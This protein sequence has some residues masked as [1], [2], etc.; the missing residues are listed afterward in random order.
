M[1][2]SFSW[3]RHYFL[4]YLNAFPEQVTLTTRTTCLCFRGFAEKSA[5]LN[6]EKLGGYEKGCTF[7]NTNGYRLV[8]KPSTPIS[9]Y[10]NPCFYV[11]AVAQPFFFCWISLKRQ[12]IKSPSAHSLNKNFTLA[13]CSWVNLVNC[14]QDSIF[15]Q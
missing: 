4:S 1:S 14:F 5:K 6:A 2:K 13:F 9:G 7:A 10:V 8:V 12:E 15:A 11:W 3:Q